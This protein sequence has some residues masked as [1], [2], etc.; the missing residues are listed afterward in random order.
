M[1]ADCTVGQRRRFEPIAGAALRRRLEGRQRSLTL[2][3]AYVRAFHYSKAETLRDDLSLLFDRDGVLQGI[4][5][6]LES[7]D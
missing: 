1:P 5:I 3:P 7:A 4:G 6:R 2:L